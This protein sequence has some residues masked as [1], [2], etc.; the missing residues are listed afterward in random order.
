MA[1]KDLKA[2]DEKSKKLQPLEEQKDNLLRKYQCRNPTPKRVLYDNPITDQTKRW[3]AG[4]GA[5]QKSQS[6]GLL[7]E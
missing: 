7:D 6:R 1:A 2:L 5:S 3:E 4:I